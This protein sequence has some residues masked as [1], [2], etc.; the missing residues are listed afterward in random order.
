MLRVDNYSGDR[1]ISDLPLFAN[2][3]I[4]EKYGHPT[5]QQLYS[6]TLNKKAT[7]HPSIFLCY[8]PQ[9]PYP[10]AV[11]GF[12]QA[13]DVEAKSSRNKGVTC[14]ILHSVLTQQAT[15]TKPPFTHQK[16]ENL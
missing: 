2:P 12:A 6:I 13:I 4:H 1:P 14:L 16:E 5:P 15:T 7:H 10:I 3:P 11:S 8:S 9:F